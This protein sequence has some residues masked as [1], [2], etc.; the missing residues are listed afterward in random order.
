MTG[1]S[2]ANTGPAPTRLPIAVL[3]ADPRNPRKMAPEATAGLAISMET[4]GA[5]DIVFNQRTGELV[6]GHQRVAELKASGATEV[7]RHGD[8][9]FIT[10]PKTGERFPV[11]FVDWDETKQRMGNLVA[12]NPAIQGDFTPDALEQVRALQDEINFAE[13]GLAKLTADLEAQLAAER[14]NEAKGGNCDPDDVP[15][16]PAEPISKR[17]DLWILGQHKIYCGDSTNAD[18]VQRLMDGQRAIMM[19]TDPPYLVDYTGEDHPQSAERK[20]AGKSNNKNWDAYKDPETS[21]AFFSDFIR[22][23]L[24]QALVEDPVIYQWHA[25]RRQALVE[26][27]WIANGLLWH[28]QIIW[29]KS[30]PI[31]TRSHYMW[32]HEP[33]AYGWVTGRPPALRPPVS[34]ECSTVWAI[35]QRGGDVQT[36]GDEK[37]EHPTQKPVEIFKRPISYHTHTGDIVYEPF[38]GSGS[39]IIAAEQLGRRCFAMELEPTFV[40]VAV[41]RWEQFTGKKA[42]RTA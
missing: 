20:K 27:A 1:D 9:G 33:A 42:T 19:A 15:E 7:T 13:L 16:P 35:D 11:R 30:R 22:V 6:S 26:A 4:F 24:E 12:N 38:S 17:G 21:V 23:A 40:D 25:S 14:D 39:Q 34:G 3:K 36:S 18:D 10:H 8:W 29:V 5:L 32:Q 28:Q 37:V 31:L 2:V 41:A